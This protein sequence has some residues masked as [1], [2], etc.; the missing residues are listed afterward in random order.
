MRFLA[1]NRLIAALTRGTVVVEAAVRSGALNTAN[2][3][4]RLNRRGDGRPGPGDQRAVRRGPP[5][6]PQRRRRRWS[7]RGHEVLE[8]VGVV[9]A[10][11]RR[12]AARTGSRSRDR[13]SPRHQQVLDAVPVAR[14]PPADSIART[15]GMGVLEVRRRLDYLESRGLAERTEEG[16]RLAALALRDT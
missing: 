12:G 14:G 8:P 1:R 3:A 16:W 5:A 11:P 2:W 10:A 4:G 9:G 6:D 13:L 7:T 15:A